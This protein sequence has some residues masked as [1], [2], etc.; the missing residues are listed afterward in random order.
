MQYMRLQADSNLSVWT[1]QCGLLWATLL[2]PQHSYTDSYRPA[3][4]A[5]PLTSGSVSFLSC[6]VL[7]VHPSPLPRAAF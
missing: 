7:P 4:A 3:D 5:V 6:T 1:A 2:R